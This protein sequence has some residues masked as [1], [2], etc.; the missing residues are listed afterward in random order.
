LENSKKY[1]LEQ[2]GFGFLE[3]IFTDKETDHC[4]RSLEKIINGLYETGKP[5]ENRFWEIG[6]GEH[7]I[8][9]IDKPHL[10]DQNVWNF[11]TN[12]SF[13]L[14]LSNLTKSKKI[15]IW[16]SQLVW[17]PTSKGSSGNA[18]WHRDAQYW[19]F[20]SEKGLYTAWIALTDVRSS[21]GPVK[22][23]CNSNRWDKIDGLDF[24]KKDLKNQ[25]RILTKNKSTFNVVDSILNKGQVSV[26]KSLTYHSSGS[27]RDLN[28]RVGLVVHF[29]NENSR[30]V[31]VKGE[32]KN[33]LNYLQDEIFA[34]VIYEK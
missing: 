13:G 17:K 15:K 5:P 26:H 30:R 31:S 34:P 9:K 23:I 1:N 2:H 7:S 19:P 22:Y 16:H 8:I 33:Y 21:S 6:D 24:F 29:C 10:C 3:K 4:K 28:P 12:K 14:A 18:G 25:N 11:I 27:N 32:N 20:W